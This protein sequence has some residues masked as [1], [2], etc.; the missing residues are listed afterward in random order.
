MRLTSLKEK[1]IRKIDYRKEKKKNNM[2]QS[3][4]DF[5]AYD[6]L[7]KPIKLNRFKGK[8]LLI[9]NTATK[10]GFT[11][12]YDDLDQLYA[13]YK[14]KGLEI[15]DFPCNQF[16]FQAPGTPKEYHDACRLKFM[17]EFTQFEKIKVN[18]KEEHPLYRY[19]KEHS[20]NKKIKWNF[21]K[22]L[23]DRKGNVRY[24]FEPEE[25]PLSFENTIVKLLQE[26]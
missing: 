7:G 17:V 15:L 8:V 6:Y 20:N 19:L 13:K 5:I 1:R 25:T 11:N 9:V 4:Y 14:D 2:N 22:F 23:V 18:G 12:Q 10:C 24:R 26:E 21:T 3:I 16:L